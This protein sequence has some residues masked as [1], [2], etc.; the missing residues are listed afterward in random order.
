MLFLIFYNTFY[1]NQNFR[2]IWPTIDA[3]QTIN[4]NIVLD[5]G[6]YTVN[7]IQNLIE[8]FFIT[9]SFLR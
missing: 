2:I 4:Y 9:N 6:F 3:S 7:D 5:N 1:Q 8:Q